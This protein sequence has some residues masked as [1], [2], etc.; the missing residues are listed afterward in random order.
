MRKAKVHAG[1][2][3][4]HASLSR[5]P[6]NF[7]IMGSASVEVLNGQGVSSIWRVVERTRTERMTSEYVEKGRVLHSCDT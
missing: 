6:C 7:R 4:F 1:L 5:E 2:D 3:R